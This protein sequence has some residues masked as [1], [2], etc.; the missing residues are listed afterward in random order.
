[1]RATANLRYAARS[2]SGSFAGPRTGVVLL[3]IS[4]IGIGT[5][6]GPTVSALVVT[7]ATAGRAGIVRLLW[8]IVQWRVGLAWY[9]FAF[10]GLP[11]IETLGT[12]AIPGALASVT[13][14]D[15]LPE[16]MSA[17][18]F[19]VYPALLAG[20]LGEEIG[21]RGVALPRLQQLHGPVKASLILGVLWAFWHAPIW[22]SGQ[23]S[24]PSVPNIAVY[25]FWIVAVTFIFTWVFNNRQRVHGHPAARDHGRLSQ[26]IPAGSLARRRR[27][28]ERRRA[29]DV[30]GAGARLRP[31]RAAARDRH[32]RPAREAGLSLFSNPSR[33]RAKWRT[34]FLKLRR[35][36]YGWR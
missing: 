25:V 2:T 31:V 20:P 24:T 5:F 27:D 21:W 22:F 32:A 10:F 6:T 13:P 8:R 14:I 23:W 19:F 4:L 1:M 15:L 9:L 34:C 36:P 33:R 11:V 35:D 3:P 29:L 16:L 17:A 7:A 30:L 18:V 28:D 26:R 12:I